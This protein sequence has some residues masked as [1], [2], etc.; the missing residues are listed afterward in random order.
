MFRT[1]NP[2]EDQII[3]LASPASIGG[4]SNLV[5]TLSRDRYLR[6]WDK[7]EGNIFGARLPSGPGLADKEPEAKGSRASSVI[8][9]SNTTGGTPQHLLGRER[10]N[11]V[12]C[13]Y[14]SQT[15]H[16]AKNLRILVFI[17]TPHTPSSGGFFI[18]YRLSEPANGSKLE[19][20]GEK[21]ASDRTAKSA[22]KDFVVKVSDKVCSPHAISSCPVD[23]INNN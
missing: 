15:D 6:V 18:L 17:P 8:S 13:F 12:R 10:R 11:Y 7:Q 3:S 19:A 20:L 4:S 1:V 14:M 9:G 2:E 16:S 23:V 5:F 21:E 22:L